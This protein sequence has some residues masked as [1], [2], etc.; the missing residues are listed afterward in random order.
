MR[1]LN[2]YL[3]L[4]EVFFLLWGLKVFNNLHIYIFNWRIIALQCFTS[5]FKVKD[6]ITL[7]NIYAS[8]RGFY[9]NI[10]LSYF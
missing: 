6:L 3:L 10:Y 8:V 7:D 5:S 4:A 1:H 2:F 9:I